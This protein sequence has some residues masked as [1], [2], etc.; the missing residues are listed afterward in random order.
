[1]LQTI[2][3]KAQGWF[4]W[5]I[6]SLLIVVFAVWGIGSYFA[7][8]PDPVIVDVNGQETHWREFQREMT[9]TRQRLREQLGSRY[10]DQ[11]FPAELL[12]QQVVERFINQALLRDMSKNSGMRISDAQ[13][14]AA[15]R[16][17]EPFQA[18]GQFSVERYRQLLQMQGLSEAGFEQ[19]LR[20]D[21]T[22]GQVESGLVDSEFATQREVS[23]GLALLEQ[24]RTLSHMDFRAANFVDQIELDQQAIEDYYQ[25]NLARF[26]NP[27]RVTVD[28]LELNLD[29]LADKISVPE[30]QV[31]QR[32]EDAKS[33]FTSPETRKTRHILIEVAA[34]ADDAAVAAAEQKLAVIQQRLAAGEAFDEVAKETSDDPGSAASGGDLGFVSPGSMV[35]AFDKATFALPVNSVSEPVRTPFGYHLIEVT[36]VRGG[37]TRPY[38]EVR[39]EL[40]HEMQVQEAEQQFYEMGETLANVSYEQP[41]SLEPAAEALGLSIQHA[42]PFTR[43]GG[44]GIA[45]D[46]AFADAAFRSDLI[47][48]GTN[49]EV[50]ELGPTHA[51]VIRVADHQAATPKPLDD[52]RDE[53]EAALR[54]VEAGKEAMRL[55]KALLEQLEGGADPQQ[56]AT[57]HGREWVADGDISRS[58]KELPAEVLQALFSAAPPPKDSVGSFTGTQ[59][60]ASDYMLLW[61]SSVTDSDVDASDTVKQQQM[62]ATL[63]RIKA[64]AEYTA[65]L[66]SL[67]QSADIKVFTQNIP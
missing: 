36:E 10:D 54:Q 37:E 9:Q 31:E 62:A 8:D 46:P 4:A 5:V 45:Q 20:S 2:R 55:G 38:S 25:N 15:I 66:A 17:Y 21:E 29:S 13:L 51:V 42:G 33:T 39:A 58:N 3:D 7:P 28:Y 56:V 47:A 41:D 19:R 44:E 14:A 65:L 12:Q 48:S 43:D 53:V 30:E 59:S 1:M 63:A 27:E 50:L 32:Y 52:V 34:D 67:R 11:L 23:R 18:D 26:S 40:L 35:P 60:G 64:Q 22:I 6:V 16:G 57:E 24:T 49:S 61:I